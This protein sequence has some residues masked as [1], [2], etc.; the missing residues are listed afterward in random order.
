MS[1]FFGLKP[2]SS[3][4]QEAE[5]FENDVMIRHNNQMLVGSVYV[6]MQ[7]QSWSVAFAYNVSRNPG[8]HGHENALEAKYSY[9]PGKDEGPVMFRSDSAQ[10][11]PLG[12][13]VFSHPD[14]FVSY[15]IEFE[16]TLVN[17]PA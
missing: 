8:L 12:G 2:G 14:A 15:A 10:D 13:R 9:R 4:R 5:K 16:R 11:I 7:D 6:D 1:K 17:R 3:A